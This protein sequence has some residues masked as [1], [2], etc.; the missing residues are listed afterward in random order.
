MRNYFITAGTNSTSLANI[1]GISKAV[2]DVIVDG[3]TPYDLHEIDN[4]RF[5]SL[6]NNKKFLIDRVQE[7][8]GKISKS[9]P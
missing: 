2:A 8:P 1:G 5:L 3:Y 9:I 7:V 4:S 6:H